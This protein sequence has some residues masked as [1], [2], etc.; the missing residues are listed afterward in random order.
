MGVGDR[1]LWVQGGVDGCD[2]GRTLEVPRVPFISLS[3]SSWG[4]HSVFRA[5]EGKT[6]VYGM[7]VPLPMNDGRI[8]RCRVHR[9]LSH[10]AV[11][12]YERVV[13]PKIDRRA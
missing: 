4:S 10:S 13:A 8:S 1:I 6:N 5:Q 12:M 11:G 2:Q 7:E 9:L 3:K